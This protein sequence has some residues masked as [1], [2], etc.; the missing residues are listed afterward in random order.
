MTPLRDRPISHTPL[1][2]L[3]PRA[4]YDDGLSHP[5]TLQAGGKSGGKKAGLRKKWADVSD[6]KASDTE[7]DEERRAL[8]SQMGQD[9]VAPQRVKEEPPDDDMEGD[10]WAAHSACDDDEYLLGDFEAKPTKYSE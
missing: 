8:D 3:P 6:G 10:S 5:S 4:R 9:P 2:Y 1:S 7:S